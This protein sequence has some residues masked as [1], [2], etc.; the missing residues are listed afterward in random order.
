M[1]EPVADMVN[2]PT[3]DEHAMVENIRLRFEAGEVYT[4]CGRIVVS[5]N[6]FRWLPI[7]EEERVV[8]YHKSEDPF[9]TEGPHVYSITHAALDEI[10]QQ[11]SRGQAMRS[12]SILV[13]GESG[14]GKTE[15]TKICMRYLA[16]VDA[17][18]DASGAS[19]HAAQALTEQ[20]LKTSPILEAFGNAQTVRNDN[21][22][23]FGKFM[24]L[25]YSG[26]ARQLGAHIYTY[27]LERSRVINPP[28]GEANYHVSAS[29]RP[30]RPPIP[31][32]FASRQLAS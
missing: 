14:A 15:A 26:R 11:A 6:P 31:Q 32:A 20:V 13:S 23:R 17:L 9:A 5:V 8:R 16:V 27:L 28:E 18:C 29:I 2:L 19:A 21:S 3:L 10:A 25:Q 7:Y 1:V 4:T 12:Q 24:Q 22:S 30:R